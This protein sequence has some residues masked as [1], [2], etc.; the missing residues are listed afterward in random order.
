MPH[1]PFTFWLAFY[2]ICEAL[3]VVLLLKCAVTCLVSLG[4]LEEEIMAQ[5]W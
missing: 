4:Q 2:V 5:M 1:D 3:S